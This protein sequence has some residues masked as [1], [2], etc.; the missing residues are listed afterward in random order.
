M[1]SCEFS[2]TFRHTFLKDNL[3][4]IASVS[5]GVQSSNELFLGM[6]PSGGNAFDYKMQKRLLRGFIFFLEKLAGKYLWLN[7]L[8][9][10][11]FG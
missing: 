10:K 3:R 9:E 6:H 5:R 1:F 11:I 4:T 7:N 2:E 8:Q